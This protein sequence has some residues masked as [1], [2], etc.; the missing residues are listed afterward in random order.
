MKIVVAICTF[1]RLELLRRL[2][3]MLEKQDLRVVL[4]GVEIEVLVVDNEASSDTRALY[5]ELQPDY[6]VPL[7]Y[8]QQPEQGISHARNSAIEYALD[9]S[10]NYLAFIDDDDI[11]GPDWLILLWR[12]QLASEA[13]FVFGTWQLSEDLPQWVHK[14]GIFKTRKV[15]KKKAAAE[16]RLPRMASTCNVLIK[17][18]FIRQM[19]HDGML[20]DPALG[21]S[22]GE[23]KDFFIRALSLGAMFSCAEDS[24]VVRGH[25]PGRYQG[26]GIVKRGFKNGSSRMRRMRR[27]QESSSFSHFL[28][29]ML[30]LVVVTLSL[31]FSVFSHSRLMH[32]LYR[33][34]KVTG[35]IY[36]YFG[37]KDYAYYGREADAAD[38]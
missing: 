8:V 11:P 15:S 25:Q 18:S 16:P 36:G 10:A 5:S 6:F 7:A 29:S 21:R 34:G 20:F 32:Q 3:F 12:E 24:Y 22:G 17:C 19:S 26:L 30:K 35:V 27:H 14:S 2:L 33:V 23:D 1:Q 31:P 37:K 38:K 9:N 4:A 28:Q 13:D